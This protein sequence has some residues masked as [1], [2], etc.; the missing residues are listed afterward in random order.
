[1]SLL[2]ARIASP[3]RSR[4]PAARFLP[5][6]LLLSLLF[7]QTAA[8]A[9]AQTKPSA[10]M[11]P[12]TVTVVGEGTVR[13]TPD[14]AHVTLGVEVVD[15]TARTASQ[16][17]NAQMDAVLDALA[18]QG[19]ALE[20]IQTTGYSVSSERMV[21]PVMGGP[22]GDAGEGLRYRVSNT[23]LVTIRDLDQVAA[24]LDAAIA[25]GA[26]QVYGVTYGLDDASAPEAEAR[27]LAVEDARRQAQALAALAGRELGPVLRVSEILDAVPPNF[28]G[29]VAATVG[30]GPFL[31]GEL[32]YTLRLEVTYE[33]AGAS[34]A[35]ALA[36]A[37]GDEPQAA[38]GQAAAQP[39]PVQAA[40]QATLL[41]GDAHSVTV[42][43]GDEAALRAF[44]GLLLA[45]FYPGAP[46][47]VV[48]ATVG[49]L[50]VH[51]P[52]SLTLPAGTEVIGSVERSGDYRHTQLFLVAPLPAETFAAALREQLGEQGF[53]AVPGAQGSA[54]FRTPQPASGLLCSEDGDLAVDLW[55]QDIAEGRSQGVLNI[56]GI[57]PWDGPCAAPV[58]A[59][60]GADP[61]A[62]FPALE[63]PEGVTIFSSGMGG[64]G[65]R[66]E[67]TAEMRG[68]SGVTELAEHFAEQLRAGGWSQTSASQTDDLAWSAWTRAVEG[69]TWVATFALVRQAEAP[70][71]VQASLRAVRQS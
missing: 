58:E 48:T 27:A 55:F 25:A 53:T 45:P 24:V 20:D 43:G 4:R 60:G 54:V 49:A 13:V 6:A 42:Q 50:P 17:A 41:A 68:V 2:T 47:T 1:M 33:L 62:I 69:V 34:Q 30:T 7:A 11:Q 21:E 31:P 65:N 44:L 59:P 23:V 16:T 32:R 14:I 9:Q 19:I 56:N 38:E 39:A 22:P 67:V 61:T 15:A 46:A 18:A 57:L 8:T 35:A 64:G 3:A 51:L 37:P 28:L 66:V 40:I 10:A 26:N 71:Q 52:I 12:P 70:D 36:P 63:A 5:L 29:D